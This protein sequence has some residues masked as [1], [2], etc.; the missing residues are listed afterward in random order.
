MWFPPSRQRRRR[1]GRVGRVGSRGGRYTAIGGLL[2]RRTGTRV[3]LIQMGGHYC[4]TNIGKYFDHHAC[5]QRPQHTF[6]GAWSIREYIFFTKLL[7]KNE[8]KNC[9]STYPDVFS[10]SDFCLSSLDHISACTRA[11]FN[12]LAPPPLITA[13]FEAVRAVQEI[14]RSEETFMTVYFEVWRLGAACARACA[15]ARSRISLFCF[16]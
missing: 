6:F 14:L 1:R 13:E 4:A 16:G 11:Q 12:E 2:L 8:K 7:R 3:W 10:T 5:S 15:G 9:S